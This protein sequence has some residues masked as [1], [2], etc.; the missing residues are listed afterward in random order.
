MIAVDTRTSEISEI[1][2]NFS[3]FKEDLPYPITFN[4]KIDHVNSI[5]IHIS[6]EVK[7]KI[8]CKPHDLVNFYGK[9]DYTNEVCIIEE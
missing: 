1:N 3:K 8:G 2:I 6:K 9:L 5:N 4:G 7:E